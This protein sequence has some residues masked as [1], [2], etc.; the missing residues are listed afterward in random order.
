LDRTRFYGIG[1]DQ[2]PQGQSGRPRSRSST[3]GDY[4]R[5]I[6]DDRVTVYG[7]HAEALASPF[8]LADHRNEPHGKSGERLHAEGGA[9]QHA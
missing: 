8:G 6:G 2:T 9:A 7:A 3:H 5:P 1:P 4:S